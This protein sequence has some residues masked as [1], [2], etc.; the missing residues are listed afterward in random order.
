ME[1]LPKGPG[2]KCQE[3]QKPG[4]LKMPGFCCLYQG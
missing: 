3:W 2:K 4:I 1:V